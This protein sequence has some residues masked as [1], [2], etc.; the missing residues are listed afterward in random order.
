MLPTISKH[1]TNQ[2]DNENI[3][4]TNLFEIRMLLWSMIVTMIG[5]NSRL[6]L[7]RQDIHIQN[8]FIQLF[9]NFI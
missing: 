3:E 6:G 7:A 4:Y 1:K 9:L 2:I 5:C 8:L